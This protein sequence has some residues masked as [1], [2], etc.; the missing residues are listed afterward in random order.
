MIGS[1]K[2]ARS[3]GG[4]KA[5]IVQVLVLVAL[6]VG[7]IAVLTGCGGGL[8]GTWSNDQEGTVVITGDKISVDD[9]SEFGLDFTYKIDGD[10]LL[11]TLE[12]LV[13]DQPVPYKLDG[14]T[15]TLSMEGESVTF[16]RK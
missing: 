12:G 15:L 2:H 9:G 6:V 14:D 7:L 16:T 13:T 10:N 11:L 1:L 8:E 5:A 3:A 4:N